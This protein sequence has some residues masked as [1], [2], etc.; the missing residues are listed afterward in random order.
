MFS[1]FTAEARD[2]EGALSLDSFLG[3]D[4]DSCQSPFAKGLNISNLSTYISKVTNMIEDLSTTQNWGL[5]A[6][7]AFLGGVRNLL[8]QDALYLQNK[9]SDGD[10]MLNQINHYRLHISLNEASQDT[11]LNL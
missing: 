2:A 10:W 6:W 8:A 4:R 1:R 3:K 11:S 7:K 9:M 5:D